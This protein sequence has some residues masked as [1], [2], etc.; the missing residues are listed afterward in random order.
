[1]SDTLVWISGASSGLGAALAASVP[2]PD[3]HIIDISRSGA[4]GVEHLPADLADPT[5]WGAVEAHFLAQ[6]GGFDGARAIFIHNA[7]T[8]TPVGFAGE[9]DSRAYRDAVLLNAASPL[10][11]GH[12]FL[13]AV[14]ASGFTGDAQL[15]M[16]TSGAASNPYPGWSAYSAGKAATDMWVRTA[17]EE[18]R[19]RGQRCRVVAV[20]PGVVDTDMQ[21][22]VRQSSETDFPAVETFHEYHRTGRLVAPEVAARGIWDLV[23]DEVD[24]GAVV[25]LRSR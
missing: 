15:V 24:N 4:Q 8:I 1:M 18:Q 16:I 25:D 22:T 14:T 12:A 9:V 21:A 5:S 2:Y 19:R 23:T 13:H 17:G 6:L 11:L 3:A 10:Y 7:A 20:A